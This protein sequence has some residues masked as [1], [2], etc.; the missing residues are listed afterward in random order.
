M[1]CQRTQSPGF[2]GPGFIRTAVIA[3]CWA[4]LVCLAVPAVAA[5]A[6]DIFTIR[7]V[8]V[9]VRA[10]TAAAARR[11]AIAEGQRQALDR[12]LRR[13]V[14]KDDVARLP[15][16]DD[17]RVTA[18][19]SGLEFSGEKSSA[20]RYLAALTVRFD[21]EQVRAVLRLTGIPFS[22]TVSR[23]TLVVPLLEAA[24]VTRLWRPGNIWAQGW[25][26]VNH[27]TG[28]LPLVVADGTPVDRGLVGFADVRGSDWDKL[29]RLAK[30]YGA[31]G[32]I[33]ARASLEYEPGGRTPVLRGRLLR[34]GAGQGAPPE[35]VFRGEDG[36]TA[37]ALITRAAHS[38]GGDLEEEW[39]SKTLIGYGI[40]GTVIARIPI[41]GLESWLQIA[42][43]LKA[44]GSI[45][46]LELD[47][48]TT[49]EAV[50]AIHYIGDL[51][52]LKIALAQADLRLK[53]AGDRYIL[54]SAKPEGG[55]RSGS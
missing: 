53:E 17:S 44:I 54:V 41:S 3:V 2:S 35:F 12:L 15:L 34:P 30:R 4:G 8:A 7:D 47:S 46:R 1:D 51:G 19:V 27:G 38:L 5:G 10:T 31:S 21:A 23:K 20:V 55:D 52:Q 6:S 18:L 43:I 25:A 22:E 14:K 49:G 24:G 40:G 50:A 32:V 16:F 48:L 45:R 29:A 26:T 28:L 33:I 42:K 9:D 39:K 13:L 11:Q 36:E 37:A